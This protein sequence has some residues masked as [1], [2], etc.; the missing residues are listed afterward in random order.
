VIDRI[1]QFGSSDNIESSLIRR[2]PDAARQH[3]APLGSDKQGRAFRLFD[4]PSLSAGPTTQASQPPPFLFHYLTISSFVDNISIQ[5]EIDMSNAAIRY[6]GD[7]PASLCLR[8]SAQAARSRHH[9]KRDLL[10]SKQDRLGGGG[11][12]ASTNADSG[13]PS[14][15]IPANSSRHSV[16]ERNLVID[17]VRPPPACYDRCVIPVPLAVLGTSKEK[18][19]CLG[20]PRGQ[21][22]ENGRCQPR[23]ATLSATDHPLIRASSAFW[24]HH[25]GSCSCLSNRRLRPVHRREARLAAAS[26]GITPCQDSGHAPRLPYGRK[27][28]TGYCSTCRPG[29]PGRRSR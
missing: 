7:R 27:A 21:V 3:T 1:V 18:L 8:F 24:C 26:P 6:I 14:P 13:A 29:Q 19:P 20:S 12:S 22:G 5:P 16:Q 23:R 17:V 11:L 4:V 15:F 9:S 28:G 25:C 10:P 2:G